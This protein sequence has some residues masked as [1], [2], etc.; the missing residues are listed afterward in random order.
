MTREG[1]FIL[2]IIVLV[3]TSCNK[4]ESNADQL[5]PEK[6][7]K[8]IKEA[9]FHC[10]PIVEN[11]KAMYAYSI[12]KSSPLYLPM[13]SIKNNTHLFSPSD[14]IVVSPN[15]DTYHTTASLECQ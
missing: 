6:V 10:F 4:K 5:S 7:E 14:S 12:P 13:N 15:N 8:L 3:N 2:A 9:C 1:V 11:Y